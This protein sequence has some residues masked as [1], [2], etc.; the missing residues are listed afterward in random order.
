MVE[1]LAIETGDQGGFDPEE[2]LPD[3]MDVMVVCSTLIVFNPIDRDDTVSL[4]ESAEGANQIQVQLAHFSVKEFLLSNRCS[5]S[6]SFRSQVCHSIIVESCLRYLLHL[7]QEGPLTK[8]LVRQYPLSLYAAEQW[9][10]HLQTISAIINETLL[11]LTLWFLTEE[12]ASILLWVQ[13]YD[14]DNPY[15]ALNP[16]VQAHDVAQPLYYATYIGVPIVVEKILGRKINVN[17][18]GGYYGTALQAAS[19]RGH[20]AVVK[21]L[22]EAGADVK[23]QGGEY[24]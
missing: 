1:I 13:L 17:A 8:E 4:D 6:Q 3:P 11:E 5:F 23:A 15:R 7:C 21:M 10:Q 16:S 22:L 9:W 24:R 18:Q 2:R 12:D 20:G 14:V 19:V